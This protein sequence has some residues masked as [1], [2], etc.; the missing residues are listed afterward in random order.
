MLDDGDVLGALAFALTALDA[1]GSAAIVFNDLL[2]TAFEGEGTLFVN[3]AGNACIVIALEDIGNGDVHGAA[4]FAVTA[5]GAADLCQ[6]FICLANIF[7]ELFFFGVHDIC[8]A[9]AEGSD[10]LLKLFGSADT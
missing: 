3:C 2:I 6:T 9:R 8:A 4:G 10:V 7:D 1:L 5:A